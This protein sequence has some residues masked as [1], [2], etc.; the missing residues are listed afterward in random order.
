MASIHNM[1]FP[2]LS[3]DKVIE[4]AQMVFDADRTN[5]IDREVAANHLGYS[6]LSGASEK[7][8][9]TIAHYGLLEK[10]GKR[11]TKITGLGM[12]IFAPIDESSRR[13]A[14]YKAGH[15]PALFVAIDEHFD[16]SPSD[17]ALQNWLIRESFVDRTIQSIIK[18]YAGT[19]QCMKEEGAFESSSPSN[20]DSANLDP[21]EHD[22]GIEMENK[23]EDQRVENDFFGTFSPKPAY[24]NS[25][26]DNDFTIVVDGLRLQIQCKNVDNEGLG[27]LIDELKMYQGI[28][29]IRSKSAS[30]LN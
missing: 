3:L 29:N 26:Q 28:L 2:H 4:R 27:R 11:Q 20:G 6:G 5:V 12:D 14:I 22:G 8:L 7:M 21:L 24:R 18:A 30:D 13:Q 25:D 16:S 9:A 1:G 15:L 17:A 19:K 10:A 23:T